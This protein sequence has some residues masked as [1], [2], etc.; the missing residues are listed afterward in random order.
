MGL[1][2]RICHASALWQQLQ[3]QHVKIC[4][5]WLRVHPH[6]TCVKCPHDAKTDKSKLATLLMVADWLGRSPHRA[7]VSLA[8]TAMKFLGLAKPG[9]ASLVPSAGQTFRSSAV[10]QRATPRTLSPYQQR[11]QMKFAKRTSHLIS[12]V[13]LAIRRG[14]AGI[15]IV[16]ATPYRHSGE[17]SRFRTSHHEDCRMTSWSGK[18]TGQRSL[19]M[20]ISG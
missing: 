10:Q 9:G 16:G 7:I 2:T 8:C 17:T 11:H 1:S 18:R 6:C 5:G 3:C 13:L 12:P 4:F 19:I 14:I 15:N 20:S